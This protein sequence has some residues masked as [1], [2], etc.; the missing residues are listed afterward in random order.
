MQVWHDSWGWVNNVCIFIFVW[1]NSSVGLLCNSQGKLYD[2][3]KPPPEDEVP[4]SPQGQ[5]CIKAQDTSVG[6]EET[7]TAEW[8][9]T[10]SDEDAESKKE[11]ECEEKIEQGNENCV[12]DISDVEEKSEEPKQQL[13][14]LGD[15]AKLEE[16]SDENL[17]ESHEDLDNEDD[18]DD[19]LMNREEELLK[20]EEPHEEDRKHIPVE[21]NTEALEELEDLLEKDKELLE[22]KGGM[23]KGIWEG[24]YLDS[25]RSWEGIVETFSGHFRILHHTFVALHSCT[26]FK[27]LSIN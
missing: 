10:E 14:E 23:E 8:S 4:N 2:Y 1:I 7:L 6:T 5:S 16:I 20:D 21:E 12:E 3:W 22:I 17:F 26:L 18:D 11:D 24:M 15:D 27:D 19:D 13:M 25:E 9:S